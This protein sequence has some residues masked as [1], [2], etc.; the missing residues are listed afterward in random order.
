MLRRA[1]NDRFGDAALQ[2]GRGQRMSALGRL[3]QGA[4]RCT[5]EIEAARR[6]QFGP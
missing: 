5:C 6:V 4:S 1:W 3:R 2:S